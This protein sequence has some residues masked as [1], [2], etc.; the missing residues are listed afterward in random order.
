MPLAPFGR[1]LDFDESLTRDQDPFD[2]YHAQI[3]ANN[4]VSAW[5]MSGQCRVNLWSTPGILQGTPV[6]N[7]WARIMRVEF[8]CSLLPTRGPWP[9]RVRLA[10]K[11]GNA[12]VQTDYRVGIGAPSLVGF[13]LLGGSPVLEGDTDS[14]TMAWLI[15]DTI[16]PSAADGE[17]SMVDMFTSIEAGLGKPGTAQVCMLALEVWGR[18]SNATYPARLHGLIAEEWT[19]LGFFGSGSF[20]G[21]DVGGV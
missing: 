18:T 1:W 21:A 7:Q 19:G 3:V 10:G 14:T 2:Y 20:G 6:A 16:V 8:P 9:F 15:E 17:R 11:A 5:E 12:G 13:Y 4:A